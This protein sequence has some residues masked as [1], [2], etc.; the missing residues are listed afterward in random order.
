MNQPLNQAKATPRRDARCKDRLYLSGFTNVDSYDDPQSLVEHLDATNSNPQA[1]FCR[2]ELLRVLDPR[3]GDHVLDVGC[4]LGHMTLELAKFVGDAG[5]VTGIDRSE[6]MIAEAKR[7][8]HNL[9]GVEFR[10]ED[11]HEMSFREHNFDGC[12]VIST[13]VHVRSPRQVLSEIMRVLKPGCRV[14]LQENDWQTMVLKTNDPVIDETVLHMLRKSFR[15]AGIGREVATLLKEVGFEDIAVRSGTLSTADYTTADKAWRIQEC[16]ERACRSGEFSPA[17]TDCL[18]SHFSKADESGQFFAAMTGVI[19]A[20][21][22][23]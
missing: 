19:V 4:G 18:L 21:K 9:P 3:E 11:A 1:M 20:A 5:R 16:L 23:G 14:A 12:I 22:A 13:L 17:R 8:T 10:V 2:Q 6:I 7:R 15:K